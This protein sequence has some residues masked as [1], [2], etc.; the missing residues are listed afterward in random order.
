MYKYKEKK[1]DIYFYMYI[2]M[3]ILILLQTIAS[4]IKWNFNFYSV[5]M[6]K[7]EKYKFWK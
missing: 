7:E 5:L 2:K 6:F 1:S 4:N 3:G